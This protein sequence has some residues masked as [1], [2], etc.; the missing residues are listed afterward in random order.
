MGYSE[1]IVSVARHGAQAAQRT[2]CSWA[3]G[4][5]ESCAILTYGNHEVKGRPR[6]PQRGWYFTKIEMNI[7][8][9]L[10]RNQFAVIY[11][12]RQMNSSM[13]QLKRY[14]ADNW[15]DMIHETKSIYWVCLILRLHLM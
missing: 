13:Y 2:P 3:I 9:Q 7:E 5:S 1:L 6:F 4:Y 14:I 11:S 8:T 15:L 10:F 12:M